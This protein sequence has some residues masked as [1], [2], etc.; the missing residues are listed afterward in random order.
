M[1]DV[2]AR[3]RSLYDVA[4][5]SYASEPGHGIAFD[6][7][8]HWRADLAFALQGRGGRVAADVGAGTGVFSRFLAA[9]GYEVVGVEPSSGMIEQALSQPVAGVVYVQG[10]AMGIPE[11]GSGWDLIAAR[12]S[13]CY[14]ED[15]LRAFRRW[16][17]LLAPGGRVLIVE[18]L[19]SRASWSDGDLVD[20]LPLS[21]VQTRAS[22]TYLLRC[23]GF[24][25]VRHRWLSAV[26]RHHG[27]GDGDVGSRY[28]A[29][30][31]PRA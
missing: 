30:A 1:D 7:L 11:R 24:G 16:L 12:Q 13:V 3:V 19:W 27:L 20:A 31:G 2:N 10:D 17:K 22:L 29:V 15:P 5:T 25:S 4:A 23:A 28:A 6:E 18:G 8:E 26:N 9:S 14:L 21:C